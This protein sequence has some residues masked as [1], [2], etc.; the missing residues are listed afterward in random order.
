MKKNKLLKCIFSITMLLLL[1]VETMDVY[2]A[3]GNVGVTYTVNRTL[4]VKGNEEVVKGTSNNNY[5]AWLGENSI[6]EVVW[7]VIGANSDK[8]KIDQNGVLSVSVKETAESIKVRATLSFQE[9]TEKLKYAEIEVLLKEKEYVI[10]A[11]ESKPIIIMSTKN[12]INDL[13]NKLN[14]YSGFNVLVKSSYESQEL[15]ISDYSF[16]YDKLQIAYNGKLKAG[17]YQIPYLLN[18]P[19]YQIDYDGEIILDEARETNINGDN[20]VYVKIVVEDKNSIIGNNGIVNT[21][22]YSN[23]QLYICVALSSLLSLI[24]IFIKNRKKEDEERI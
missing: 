13:E 21:G 14:E 7:Q 4:Q 12:S 3:E 23:L 8:T 9:D 2:A 11:I 22:D 15:S 6:N 17:E 16:Y 20:E 24:I 10:D 18:L 5:L 19:Y 1:G